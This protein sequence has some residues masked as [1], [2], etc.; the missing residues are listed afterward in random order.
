MF[1]TAAATAPSPAQLKR[2][3]TPAGKKTYTHTR[4]ARQKELLLRY[5][6]LKFSI[7]LLFY[8]AKR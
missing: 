4:C 6:T 7:Q 5:V 8:D 2:N 3:S 1:F